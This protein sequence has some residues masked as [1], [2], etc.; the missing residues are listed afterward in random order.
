MPIYIPQ[1]IQLIE[2]QDLYMNKIEVTLDTTDPHLNA[3]NK[4]YLAFLRVFG[5]RLFWLFLNRRFFF[6]QQVKAGISNRSS[7]AGACRN[8]PSL[9][10]EFIARR[11]ERIAFETKESNLFEFFF[12]RH[13]IV[14]VTVNADKRVSVGNAFTHHIIQNTID[15]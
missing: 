2:E 5:F 12:Q 8:L 10:F 13:S 15:W 9:S 1:N 6:A 14:D 3:Y 7:S 4:L 11:I